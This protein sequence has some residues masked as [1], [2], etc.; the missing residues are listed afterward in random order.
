M[1][2]TD[3]AADRPANPVR[4]ITLIVIS[5]GAVLFLYGM[6]SDRFTPHTSQAIVQAYLVRIA[7]EVAGKVIEVPAKTD[8]RIDAGAVLFRLDPAQYT[9]AVRRAEAQL[10]TAG[11][12]IGAN[13][14]GVASAEAKLAEA[15]AKRENIREQS[16][17]T[18]ELVEKGIYT[19]ARRSQVKA[20]LDS[21][22]ATVG[23]AEAELERARQTLGPQGSDNPQIREAM[24]AVA[25]ANL[26]LARTTIYAPSE[27]GV[28]NLQLTIGQVLNKAEAAMTYLDLRETWVEA[29]FRENSLEHISIGDAAEIV[30]DIKPGRVYRGK[31][32]AF[33]YGV[34]NRDVNARTGLPKIS[35]QRDWIR[36]PQPFLVRIEF[37]PE[38]PKGMR[39][40]S[41]A[42]VTVYTSGS[43]ILNAIGWIK[44]RFIALLSYVQ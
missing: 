4:R 15:I 1:A 23:Q 27:G 32:K 37:D 40:G 7:P 2:E 13:T 17:R 29:A 21:A 42:N 8:Q 5:I 34:S 20:T 31:V 30:L 6:I 41:Q 16:A 38:A 12:S 22:E 43:Y 11:Q 35:D 28:T 25:Q 36:S 3:D 18:F 9:L 26:D 24:V 14:A 33:G 10:A 19:E 39:Y 44:M